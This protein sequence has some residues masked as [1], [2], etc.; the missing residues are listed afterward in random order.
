MGSW[1]VGKII[2]RYAANIRMRDKSE[3][4]VLRKCGARTRARIA[5]GTATSVFSIPG[6]RADQAEAMRSAMMAFRSDARGPNASGRPAR[7]YQ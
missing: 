5:S 1:L 3:S 2:C 7:P 6:N 4:V